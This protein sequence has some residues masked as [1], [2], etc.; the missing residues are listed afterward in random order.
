MRQSTEHGKR[1]K[2]SVR[3]SAGRTVGCD[4]FGCK[5]LHLAKGNLAPGQV[6]DVTVF[7]PDVE[8]Q[9]DRQQCLSKG[10]NTPFHGWP[11]RGKNAMTIVSGE[12]VWRDETRFQTER[13]NPEG[14]TGSP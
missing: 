10:K 1:Q 4:T 13:S 14:P 11:M 9:F 5:L 7:D 8:W 6:A 12:V 2:G 3:S